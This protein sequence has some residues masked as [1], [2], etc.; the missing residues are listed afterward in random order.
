MGTS[1]P[2]TENEDEN[3]EDEPKSTEKGSYLQKLH[4]WPIPGL[5]L[6]S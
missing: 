1:S 6:A 3:P 2:F 5:T 4:F